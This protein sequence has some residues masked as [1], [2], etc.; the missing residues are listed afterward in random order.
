MVIT[1]DVVRSIRAHAE[2]TYPE[3]GCGFLLGRVVDGENHVTDL[4]EAENRQHELRERRYT[5]TAADYLAATRAADGLG[6]D[7]VGFYHSHPDHPPEP[8]PTDLAEATFP[9]FTYVIVSVHGGRSERLTA[10]RLAND[11]ARFLADPIV[12]TEQVN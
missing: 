11:R 6:V 10:W 12:E 4:H 5:I 7:I 9:G 2:A 3:E 1:P 8:S